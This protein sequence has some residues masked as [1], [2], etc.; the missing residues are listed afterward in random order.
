MF[1]LQSY[2]FTDRFMIRVQTLRFIINDMKII[3]PCNVFQMSKNLKKLLLFS[4][5]ITNET[6][7]MIQAPPITTN[8]RT[9]SIKLPTK[10]NIFIFNIFL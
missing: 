3:G 6:P 10:W 5:D 9:Y 8:S 7:S 2:N 4:G 1:D